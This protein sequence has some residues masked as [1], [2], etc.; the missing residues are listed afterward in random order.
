MGRDTVSSY[1]E[2]SAL[3]TRL[4]TEYQIFFSDGASRVYVICKIIAS[5]PNGRDYLLVKHCY[6]RR[7][8][9]YLATLAWVYM[10]KEESTKEIA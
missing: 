5:E 7:E 3:T 6:S 4:I 9:C 2:K 1:L 10:D 8:N